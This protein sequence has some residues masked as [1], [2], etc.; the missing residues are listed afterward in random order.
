[1]RKAMERWEVDAVGPIVDECIDAFVD[2]GEA[3]LV[4]ELTLPFPVNVI[5]SML[6]LPRAALAQFH[7]LPL[8]PTSVSCV[9]DRGIRASEQLRDYFAGILA[10]RRAE[11]ANDLMSILA[12][13]ELDGQQL[14]NEE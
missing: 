3:D 6:G 9:W 11:P 7:R 13:A 8:D 2:R 1:S 4:R 12:A 14:T 10:A 5:A